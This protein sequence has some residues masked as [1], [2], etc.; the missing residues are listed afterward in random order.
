M[1]RDT[2][3]TTQFNSSF[4]ACEKDIETILR[5]LF[6]EARPYSDI[7]KRL[8]VIQ[9]PDCLDKEYDVS[10]WSLKRLLDE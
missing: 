4:L 9:S 5:K 7:L 1:R 2:I 8:L 3:L 6:I 10:E